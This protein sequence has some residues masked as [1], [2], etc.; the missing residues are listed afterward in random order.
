MRLNSIRI[1][2][3]THVLHH[4]I[5]DCHI[6]ILLKNLIHPIT[7]NN[8]SINSQFGWIYTWV[9]ELIECDCVYS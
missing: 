7:L 6:S 9:L 5:S 2:C 8:I 4:L 3:K 1:R